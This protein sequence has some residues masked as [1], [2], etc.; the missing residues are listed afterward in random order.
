VGRHKQPSKSSIPGPESLAG[1]P[2]WDSGADSETTF[3]I[4][5]QLV[6]VPGC[7]AGAQFLA[8]RTADLPGSLVVWNNAAGGSGLLAQ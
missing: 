7:P 8:R 1:V 4:S 6:L 5:D 3:A 2:G